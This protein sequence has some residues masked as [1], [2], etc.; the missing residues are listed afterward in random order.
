MTPIICKNE[1]RS[2]VNKIQDYLQKNG[3]IKG[4][5]LVDHSEEQVVLLVDDHPIEQEKADIWWEGFRSALEI[6]Q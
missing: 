4:I 6:S 1:L 5:R 2:I 3:T